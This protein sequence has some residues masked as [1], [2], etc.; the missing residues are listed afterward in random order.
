MKDEI[1]NEK[2]KKKRKPGCCGCFAI[3]CLVFVLIIGA[4]VGVGWY[5]GDKYMKQYFDMS[6]TDAFG[7]VGGLYKADEKKIVTNAPD[8]TDEQ[9]FYDA[10]GE[11]LYLKDGTLNSESFAAISG[12]LTGG[13]SGGGSTETPTTATAKQV[14]AAKKAAENGD[15]QS[16]LE[17]IICRDNMDVEKIRSKFTADY[18]YAGNYTAD[19]TVEVSDKELFSALKTVLED[20]LSEQDNAILDFLTFEQLTLGKSA[21]GN[22]VASIVAKLDVKGF[23][24]KELEG[25]PG[26]AQWAATTFLPKKIYVTASV[27]T[28]EKL[29]IDVLINQMDE[30]GKENV[31]KLIGGILKLSGAEN[32]DAKAYLSE[33]ADNA[34]GSAVKALNESL[35]LNGNVSD[36]K[37]RFDVYDAL[38]STAFSGKDVSKLELAEAYTSVIAADVDKMLENNEKLLFENKWELENEGKII[39]VY[40]TDDEAMI[41]KGATSVNYG[42]RFTA[43][44]ENK[45]LMRTEFYRVGNRTYF[46][47]VWTDAVGNVYKQSE[48]RLG[49]AAPTEN[50]Q[51][52][53]RLNIEPYTLK[54][55]ISDYEAADYDVLMIAEFVKLDSSDLAAL[56]GVGTSE[57][58]TGIKLEGLFDSGKLTEKL[59]GGAAATR[60][61]QFLH[62]TDDEL[63][64]DLTDKM[65]AR[66]MAEQTKTVFGGDDALTSSLELKFVGLTKGNP[67]TLVITDAEGNPTDERTI[68]RRFMNV[69]FIANVDSVIGSGGIIGSLIGDRIG[70]ITKLDV[71]PG[72]EDKYLKAPEI[73]YADLGKSRT[74]NLVA[75]L[76][77]IGTSAFKP[78]ELDRQLAKPVRDL[79]EKMSD[80]LGEVRVENG[81]LSVPNVF[82]VLAS[83]LF[84]ANPEKTFGG[85]TIVLSGEDV[86]VTLKG[87]YD[88][89][90][91]TEENNKRYIERTAG[92]H[93]DYE[94][95]KNKVD[96]L[97]NVGISKPDNDLGRV[98]GYYEDDA[99]N[100]MYISYDYSLAK[101]LDGSSSDTS[102]LAVDEVVVTFEIDKSQQETIDGQTY[103]KTKMWINDMSEA[104]R[105]TLE[106]MITYFDQSNENKF[107]ELETKMGAFAYRLMTTPALKNFVNNGVIG[108]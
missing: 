59:G 29:G 79:I 96:N 5:F 54:E 53:Y 45:Y 50:N 43:E 27:E 75:M 103:Y 84:T 87:I 94:V 22:A 13:S 18:D 68:E 85:E 42:D 81:E 102:L 74:D 104:E 57:K 41:A 70:V 66:L 93:Y 55:K 30:K 21:G 10:V 6:L 7:V 37:I 25:A 80:T 61:E 46:E 12:T 98:L 16:A 108:A 14:E 107:P 99:S 20:K 4:G 32:T 56:M 90:P 64:F 9:K 100:M 35:D 52:L 24:G 78:E 8:A 72:L 89:P 23:I 49:G 71:T 69:G 63:R 3:F 34:I 11:S 28:S 86:H 58:T 33:T 82:A 36:G 106:K 31:Y 95:Q 2:P 26:I 97:N 88:L 76:E 38:A 39:E 15:T 91:L 65:L 48:L 51:R 60:D 47:P 19:F 77:K 67:E 83:Q 73:E 44:F 92:T 40:S 101:Y 17:N 105:L 62:R 1:K